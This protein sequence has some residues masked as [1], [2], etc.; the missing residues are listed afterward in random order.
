MTHQVAVMRPAEV[1]EEWLTAVDNQEWQTAQAN[2]PILSKVRQWIDAREHPSWQGQGILLPV[3]QPGMVRWAAVPS[4]Y[5]EEEYVAAAGA[6]GLVPEG[7]AGSSQ[8]SRVRPLW[9]GK[10]SEQAASVLLLGGLQA[11]H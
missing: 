3:G 1:T 9:R 11:G 6:Q 5:W 10:D 2:D 7:T 8:L 4:L